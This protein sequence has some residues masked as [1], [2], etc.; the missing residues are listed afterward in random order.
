MANFDKNGAYVAIDH[1]TEAR[2]PHPPYVFFPW[3]TFLDF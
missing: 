3:V 2:T 1:Q